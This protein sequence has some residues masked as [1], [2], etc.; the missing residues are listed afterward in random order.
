MKLPSGVKF[1]S[2]FL[3]V[4]IIGLCSAEVKGEQEK[5]KLAYEDDEDIW[6]IDATSISHPSENI[7][8][9]MLKWIPKNK[10]KLGEDFAYSIG[11]EERNCS[12]NKMRLLELGNYDKDGNLLQS[13]NSSKL[14]WR[15]IVPGSVGETLHK[16]ICEFSKEKKK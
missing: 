14:E 13:L 7:V 8:R 10:S 3:S 4:L 16:A 2:I 9:T 11:L 1:L 6:Y 15:P 12:E 5:W